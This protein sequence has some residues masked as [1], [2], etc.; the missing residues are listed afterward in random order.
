MQDAHIHLQDPRLED[1]L[2]EYIQQAHE[3]GIQRCV[4][5]GTSPEDWP[6]VEELA[7]KY[8]EFILPAYGL[9]PWKATHT[10]IQN[11]YPD[12]AE[13]LE[14]LL[15]NDPHSSIGE[16]GLDRW[17]KGYEFDLQQE[18]FELQLNLAHQ[19]NRPISVHCLR[20]WG[21]LLDTLRTQPKPHRGVVLHSYGGS[22]EL[23]PELVS[24]GCHFSF[25]GYFL[26]TRKRNIQEAYQKVPLERLLIETDAPDMAPPESLVVHTAGINALPN[27]H[28]ANLL[29]N[30]QGLSRILKTPENSLQQ[31][32]EE[33]FY[34]VFA[35]VTNTIT[36]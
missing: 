31:R 12:W 26:H 32:L 8:P 34:N 3:L 19:Y 4:V 23:V 2:E 27:N 29:V 11:H 5:N 30:L 15:L 9:H 16:C 25:S 28:P 33:N 1:S 10:Q 14:E 36:N 6:R 20:A 13:Q 7:R 17:I 21:H 22:K 35:L 24:L 18:V